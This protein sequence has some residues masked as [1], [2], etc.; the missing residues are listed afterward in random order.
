MN[1]DLIRPIG[2]AALLLTAGCRDGLE[3]AGKPVSEFGEA[4]RQTM[5]A[6]TVNPAPEYDR[7]IP[8]ASAQHAAQAVERYAADKV[9]QPE[10]I[11]STDSISSGSNR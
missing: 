2:L 8:P 5:L 11:K 10:R 6:Q 7:P 3:S 1:T 9:K 4:N